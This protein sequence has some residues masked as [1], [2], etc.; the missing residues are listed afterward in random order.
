[1]PNN[2][3]NVTPQLLAQGLHALRNQCVMPRVV[4]RDY[5]SLA[6][7]KGSTVDVPIPSAIPVQDVVPGATAPAT[8]AVTPTSVPIELSQW[9]EA[10]FTLTDKDLKQIMSGTIPMQASEA[11]SSLADEVDSY[12]LG[13]YKG[14]YGYVGTAGTTPFSNAKTTEATQA[15]KV[16]NIQKAPMSNRRFII[17]AETEASAMEL[18]AF[19]DVSFNGETYGIEEGEIRQKLGFDWLMDQNIKT[20]TTISKGSW[21]VNGT[22]AVGD[23]SVDI[24]GGTTA[25]D[26]GDIFTIAGDDQTYSV[27]SHSSGTLTFAPGLKEAPADNSAFTFKADHVV[28]LALHRDAIAFAT[29][30]LEDVAMG[31]GSRIMSAMDPISGLT[32]RL[33]INRQHKQIRYSYDILFGASLVRPELA[34]R[35]AG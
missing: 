32:L 13:L 15:S 30:P 1:M 2:L 24:D 29:R 17:D 6:Q 7:Q 27:K 33:E 34:A 21:L 12:I 3:D 18:R 26:E 19:Q 35:V 11:V 25:P 14:V 20:H 23:T 4:N 8:T 10:S 16:L 9:K 28:N 22:P 31:F 5:D